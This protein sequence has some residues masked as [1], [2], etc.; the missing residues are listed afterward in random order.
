MQEVHYSGNLINDSTSITSI[1][2]ILIV[3]K[4]RT[5]YRHNHI[6]NSPFDF[7]YIWKDIFCFL[8]IIISGWKGQIARIQL[9]LHLPK[10]VIYFF[11]HCY[12]R[13]VIFYFYISIMYMNNLAMICPE[14]RVLSCFFFFAIWLRDEIYS[15]I[16]NRL[17]NI[18]L[19]ISI[20][21]V[22]IHVLEW[23]TPMLTAIAAV[24]ISVIMW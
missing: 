14:Y 22:Y 6:I 9:L 19:G 15:H 2:F 11:V 7:L 18:I 13:F 8:P 1:E 17:R 10:M 12:F 5:N 23:I 4:Y 3:R 21:P 24:I 16:Y 20:F